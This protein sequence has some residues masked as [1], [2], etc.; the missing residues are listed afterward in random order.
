LA[1]FP[2]YARNTP[3]LREHAERC[4]AGEISR[5]EYDAVDG[6]GRNEISNIALFVSGIG[7]IPLIAIGVAILMTFTP[8][9]V[10]P[11][12]TRVSPL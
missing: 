3:T 10:P 4:N 5:G 8:M 7:E 6:M 9:Q 1:A 11:T 2:G 12:T